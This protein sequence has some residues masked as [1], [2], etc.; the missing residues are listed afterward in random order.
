MVSV[1]ATSGL[2]LYGHSLGA[3]A[4]TQTG[5]P[6]QSD[7]YY[8]NG[9]TGNLVVQ[10]LDERLATLGVDLAMVRT[11]N[12]QGS[13]DGDNNDG[14]R[15]GVY[16]K[17]YGL[18]GTVN[19]SGSTITKVY[20]DGTEAVFTYDTSRSLYVSNIGEN[21]HDTLSWSSGT[22]KWTFKDGND[23]GSEVYNSSGQLIQILD[24]DGNTSTLTYTG[25]LIT[26]IVDASGQTTYLDYT[27]NNLTKVR[28][29]SNSVTQTLTQYTYDG[30]NRL[31]QVKVDLSPADN[32]I[33]DGLTYNTT[34][35][36]D[37]TSTRVASITHG[38]TSTVSFTYELVSSKYRVK[39]I[40]DGEGKVTTFTVV[41]ST[42]TDVTD[43]LGLITSYTFDAQ[44]RLTR[45]QSPT[46]GGVRLQ[47]DY[48]Y[49]SQ[50]N[51]TQVTDPRSN[52]TVLQYD[53]RGNQ[54]L[55]RDALGNTISRVFSSTNQL[56][57]ETVYVVPD[58]DGA[59]SGQP[60]TPLT[61][62]YAYDSEN[63]L[64]FVISAEGRVTEH[65]YATNGTRTSTFV[66]ANAAYSVSGLSATTTLSEA[67]LNTWVGT[68]DLTKLQRTDYAYD[69]RGQLC[70]ITA[71]ASTNASG[72]G[73]ADGTQTV[74]R[75]VYD[76]RGQLIKTIDGRG[77]ST[78]GDPNDYVTSYTYDGVGRLLT[79][80]QWVSGTQSRTT[81]NSYDDANNKLVTT[82]A[83]GLIT[84]SLYDRRGLTVSVASADASQALGTTQYKYD[85]NGRLRITVDPLGNKTHRL[86][87]DAGRVVAVIDATGSLV[88]TVYDKNSNAIKT[89]AYANRPNST[90]LASLVDGSGNPV[91]VTLASVRPSTNTSDRIS[92]T[93]YDSANRAVMTLVAHDTDA[94]KAYV[95]QT[96]Y[97]GA[98]RVTCVLSYSTAITITGLSADPTPANIT[99]LITT[100]SSDRRTRFFYDAES[101]QI[102]SL[103]AEGYLTETVYDAAGRVTRTVAYN[104]VTGS[105]LWASG[106]FAQ[107]KT[108][109]GTNSNDQNTYRFY[110]GKGQII[111]SLD[112]EGYF[113]EYQY[114]L[115][116]NQTQ[117]IRY[118][119]KGTTYTGTQT[120]AQLRPTAHANDQT[121]IN[122][123][124]GANQ[125]TQTTVNPAGTITKFSYDGVGNLTQSE[126]AWNTAEVRTTRARYDAKGRVLQELTGEGSKAVDDFIAANPSATQPQIDAVWAQ[127]SL[128]HAY[129]LA[130]RRISTTDQNGNKTLF[131]YNET[132]RLAY[133]VN[134]LGEVTETRYNALGD[135]T[136]TLRYIGRISTASLVGGVIDST[137]TNR[138]TAVA[139]AAVDIRR[140][141]SYSL[142]G[143]VKQAIDAEGFTTDNTFNAF[144]N[145]TAQTRQ[146][147]SG[148]SVTNN[149]SFDRRGLLT[150]TIEDQGALNRTTVLTYDAFGR[151]TQ[152]VA[153]SGT[154]QAQTTSFTFDRL[155][156]QLSIV[157]PAG[158]CSTTY[159]A[160][161]R[162]LTQTDA[163]SKVTTTTYDDTNRRFT[164]TTP[165]S[166]AIVTTRTRHGET[167]SIT[168]ARNVVTSY[169]YD[170][171]GNLKTEVVD[172][173]SGKLNLTTQHSYDRASLR[174][175]T[176][177]ANGIHC[178]YAYDA[179]SR[180]L[181]KTLEPTGLNIQTTYTFDGV[182]RTL[183]VVEG[184]NTPVQA[185]T[186][187]YAYD[188][189][190]NRLTVTIDPA[191]LNL[192]TTYTYNADGNV[193]TM[194][195]GANVS[196]E[197][198][199]TQYTFDKLGRRTQEAKDPSGLNI[200]TAYGFDLRDN[201]VYK[202]EAQGKPEER[203]TRNVYDTADRLIY[204][205][206]ALGGVTKNDFDANRRITQTTQYG[207]TISLTGLGNTL[208]ASDI[209]SRLTVDAAK[210]HVSRFAFDNDGRLVFTRDVLNQIVERVYDGNGNVIKTI[211]YANTIASGTA[212]TVTAI[213][214]A[215]SASAT[216][217]RVT[218]T[219]FDNA[220]RAAYT[221]DALGY[222]TETKY[223]AKGHIAETI[224]HYDAINTGSLSATPTMADIVSAL[225][226]RVSPNTAKDQH[227]LYVY[228]NAGRVK[229]IT[230]AAGKVEHYGYDALGNK[231]SFTGKKGAM[232][233][234]IQHTW[235]YTYDKAGRLIC[236]TTPVVAVTRLVHNGDGS[237][238]TT[239]TS[240]PLITVIT[241]DALG[242]VKTR[243]EAS[244][245]PEAR[246]TTYVYDRLGR[247]IQTQ[248]PQ[249]NAYNSAADQTANYVG[250][251]ETAVTPTS[252]TYY[253]AFGNAVANKDVRGYFSYKVYDK[254]GRVTH[255]VDAERFVSAYTLDAFG[256]QKTLTRYATA[257]AEA[258]FTA[259]E[260]AATLNSVQTVTAAN[261]TAWLTVSASQDRTIT[262]TYDLLNRVTETKQTAV[263]NYDSTTSQ[264]FTATPITRNEYNTFGQVVRQRT[265]KNLGT[266][267]TINTGDDQ[268]SDKYFY[269]DRLGRKT[270]E[271]DALGFLSVFQYDAN[272]NLTQQTE[273]AAALSPGWTVTS[274][275]SPT[276]T[277]PVDGN[278]V[279][280]IGF[281]RTTRFTY[282]GLNRK[283]TEVKV[284]VQYN[285]ATY[286][287]T[288]SVSNALGDLTTSYGYDA[289][290]NLVSTTDSSGAV[291]R[292]YYDALGRVTAVADP[293]RLVD[294]AG[295][296][297]LPPIS[298]NGTVVSW[299]ASPIAGNIATFKYRAKGASTW[300]DANT[301]NGL[302][303]IVD[304]RYQVS[305][306]GKPNDIYEYELSYKRAGQST[307]YAV[308]TGTFTLTG[309][310]ASG[311]IN[312]VSVVQPVYDS[313]GNMTSV[314]KLVLQGNTTG[315]TAINIAGVGTRSVTSI[316]GGQYTVD[317]SN[318]TRGVYTF[319]PVGTSSTQSGSFELFRS[320]VTGNVVL[321]ENA[322]YDSI[323][324]PDD[325]RLTISNLPKAAV[326][327]T[328]EYRPAGSSMPY[329]TAATPY[330]TAAPF[331]SQT[332]TSIG[333][334]GSPSDRWFMMG[335]VTGEGRQDMVKYEPASGYVGVWKSNGDGTF[336]PGASTYIGA[337]GTPGDRWFTLADITGDGKADLVKFEPSSGYVG[338]W[339][340][341]G[342]GTFTPGSSTYIGAGGS[343][344]DRW[345]VMADTTGDGKADIVKYEPSTG[346]ATVWTSNGNGTFTLG[347]S[348]LVGT[349]GSP[350]DRWFNVADVNGDGRADFVMYNPQD[351][352]A[353]IF[354]S[355]ANGTFAPNGSV[356][357]STGGSP[358]DRW[359][360]AADMNGDGRADLVK[361]EPT[362]G[363]VTVWLARTDGTFTSSLSTY[364]GAGGSPS[365]RWFTVADVND[366]GR[367]D[368]MRYEPASGYV[369]VWL[370]NGD[371]SFT[372]GPST[373]IGSGGSPGDRW[374]TTGDVNNSGRA[375]AIK[376]ESGSGSASNWLSDDY[377]AFATAY[378][379]MGNGQYEYRITA[380]D[381]QG[382][383]IDLTAMG[384]TAQGQVSGT[385]QVKRGGQSAPTMT[386]ATA[387]AV[388]P[389]AVMQHDIFGNV[390]HQTRYANG[391]LSANS[392]GYTL[393]IA[394]A[395][396][397]QHR[398]SF[399]DKHGHATKMV[400]AE[401]A[402]FE[403]SFDVAGN[404]V[405]T[406]NTLTDADGASRQV[407]KLYGYDRLGRQTSIT[408]VM[409][410]SNS[411]IY[412]TLP[413]A[414]GGD[415]TIG[416]G[417]KYMADMNG[418][419][420]S[421]LI[422]IGDAGSANAGKV[423]VATSNGNGFNY[424]TWNSSIRMVDD[425]SETFFGDVNGDGKAD[426]V[427][428]TGANGVQPGRVHVG[429]SDGT[430]FAYWT[431]MTSGRMVDDG[432]QS[433]LADV[434]SDGKADLVNITGATGGQPGRVHVGLSNGTS[435][436]YWTWMTAG[437]MVD[438]YSE[439]QFADVN[440]DGKQDFIDVSPP[441]GNN[442]G[443]VHV[444][445]SNGSSFA[446]WTSVSA[447]NTVSLGNW[448]MADVNGDGKADLVSVIGSGVD[449]GK[450]R[451]GLSNG[452]SFATWT[453]TST[454]KVDLGSDIK[455]AD[456]DGDGKKDLI[457]TAP[458]TGENPG[459]VYVGLSNG[460]GFNFW[461]SAAPGRVDDGGKS[462]IADVT[463]DGKVDRVYTNAANQVFIYANRLSN[464]A[465]VLDSEQSRYNAFGEIDAKGANGTWQ[466]YFHYDQA[467]RLWKTNQ[468]DGAYK[469]YFYNLAG[470]ATATITSAIE[471]LSAAASPSAVA[472]MTAANL[473]RHETKYDALGRVLAQITPTTTGTT[474]QTTQTVD[475]WGNVLSATDPR[476]ATYVTN[477]RYDAWNH[478]IEEVK[479]TT[480]IWLE[481]G[482]NRR[483]DGNSNNDRPT[484]RTYFDSLGRELAVLDANG[485]LS[486][487]KY[488]EASQVI[489]DYRADAGQFFHAY[490]ALG[491]ERIR[492][493]ALGNVRSLSYDR[494]DRLTSDSTL[495]TNRAYTYD[496]L[497]QRITENDGMGNLT[498][499]FY[500]D[501]GNVSKTRLPMASTPT[502]N[503]RFTQTAQYNRRGKKI[504][505]T[506]GL[507]DF[508]TW[509]Y[510]YFGKLQS[511]RDLSGATTS[512]VYDPE[513]GDLLSQA[514]TGGNNPGQSISY[515][516]YANGS[517][518]FITDN[519]LTQETYYEY[520]AA[521]HRTRERI[522]NTATSTTYQDVATTFDELGRVK[523]VSD[524]STNFS[525]SIDYD[526]EGNRRHTLTQ[527][528]DSTNTLQTQDYWYKY[529]AMNRITTAQGKLVSGAIVITADQ[530]SGG[531]LV[532]GQ[533]TRLYYD[534]NGNRALVHFYDH[535][536]L[537]E[538]SYSF[539]S[540]GQLTNTYRAGLLTSA[541]LYNQA[542][543]VIQYTSYSS[544]GVIQAKQ[545]STY[546][547]NGW[548]LTQES[549]DASNVTIQNLRYDYADSY[550]AVGNVRH[551]SLDVMQGM[552]YSNTY[553]KTYTK[554]SSYKELTNE[555]TSNVLLP[556]TTTQTYDVNGNLVS[557]TDSG[558][559][560][561]N[562]SFISNAQGQIIRKTQNSKT[563]DYYYQDG[564]PIG[565][566][567]DVNPNAAVDYTYT[568]VSQGYPASTPNQYTV[569]QGDT[570]K[571]I[572]LAV[573]GDAKLWYLIADANGI[574][575]D[576]GLTPGKVLTIPNVI[577]NIHN[578]SETNRVYSA[579][580]IVEDTTP[581]LPA[582]PPPPQMRGGC[583]AVGQIIVTIVAIVV[584]CLTGQWYLANYGAYGGVVAAAAVGAAAGSV[585]SQLTAMG[586]GMQDKFSWK[587]VASS[588]LVG[589]LTANLGP[590]VAGFNW[591]TAGYG[592]LNNAIS[593]GV[594]I[595]V[596]LQEKF[597]WHQVAAGAIAAPITAAID[598]ALDIGDNKRYLGTVNV[599][600]IPTRQFDMKYLFRS[601]AGEGLKSVVRQY[602]SVVTQGEG[603]IR[604]DRIFT[605]AF[606]NGIGNAIASDIKYSQEQKKKEEQDRKVEAQKQSEQ[607]K[608]QQRVA[609]AQE[610][611]IVNGQAIT[612]DGRTIASDTYANN[613]YADTRLD[614]GGNGDGA[615]GRSGN[616]DEWSN[617]HPSRVAARRAQMTHFNSYSAVPDTEGW[618][619]LTSLGLDLTPG[620]GT[621]K[622]GYQL[623]SGVDPITG[624]P[625]NRWLE[626]VG[627]ILSTVPGG[628]LLSKA[629]EKI[630]E[631][632]A[633]GGKVADSV[634]PK[635]L[636]GRQGRDEMSGSK[637]ERLSKDMK[638]NGYNS[639]HPIDVADVDGKL[640]IVDGH[641]RRQAAV[642]AGVQKVPVNIHSV[643]REQADRLLREIAELQI[644]R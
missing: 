573:Y 492:I 627:L 498:R 366:D 75:V 243:T 372:P 626:G 501:W 628:K 415:P 121:V 113:S 453:S 266:D 294:G 247:Q 209:T 195:E 284:A 384:G 76:Q 32:S 251:N 410:Q 535:T 196:A 170:R 320:T 279:S 31:T 391:A 615:Q 259:N 428:I 493:D 427:N 293:G 348:T 139:N 109:A 444:G 70:T 274:Y 234:D 130:G 47:T 552:S 77:E 585:A 165:E 583:G 483:T 215:L 602:T 584:A 137:L 249:V 273:Y 451:V 119:N 369:G 386:L 129:D 280:S 134:A 599:D 239:T 34:Y 86:Y 449:A 515:T 460:A 349:G 352:N 276:A 174:V 436:A 544:P 324:A 319:T 317:I 60:T 108:S 643:N 322:P 405:K 520:D 126:K 563:E 93:V 507:G 11:Y 419:G 91:N 176:T 46:V 55:V 48:A 275:G 344:G 12:S 343:P 486:G 379:Q 36:Y 491:R 296:Y 417:K 512:F 307:A 65:R 305:F 519:A 205:V 131:Y 566:S 182:G 213:R 445:L 169:T 464:P 158:T 315:I 499:F 595:A 367:A 371:G 572:A 30:S 487:R 476:N 485:Y 362:V 16:R 365:D 407:A 72:V 452:T 361:Y 95:T 166:V 536:A 482:T 440:G 359:F 28:V 114:D 278:S 553:Y 225:A 90:Q 446:G 265:L 8:V 153:A 221:V 398:Y 593:Q 607:Q 257:L 84:T 339:T 116:G 631:L 569:N 242:N 177:D 517:L 429:L 127:Y 323:N 633:Q 442:P 241:Y 341:N 546:N 388:T 201:L 283:L 312:V 576:A 252:T 355:Q 528:R 582:P 238:T 620:V 87:D 353:Y 562:R 450:V 260:A 155:G 335:D 151:V 82:L 236:E 230:D 342:D 268:W 471:N 629:G 497:G 590:K 222:V 619:E 297:K 162:T 58:P 184:S 469:V 49:D 21:A 186:T 606:G 112:Q 484:T 13:V 175:D 183:T 224:S 254:L 111:A 148:V 494:N 185:R 543:R 621:G 281:D 128:T 73:T 244:G 612:A 432:S 530:G 123:Y 167:V 83:N 598:N 455:F 424:W 233:G 441:S 124:D 97:D 478:R 438:D 168:D 23:F 537:V 45:T 187:Q 374:F 117:S 191:G 14:W 308:G 96:Y 447:T 157:D 152:R 457:A 580:Y 135:V 144:G 479:P 575:N 418:D 103:N 394:D 364:I 597:D 33:V 208:I 490:D 20:A 416:A 539:D 178:T 329:L 618:R 351:G 425:G 143:L 496:Q 360:L 470:Q 69:F 632:V 504:S 403:S 610:V 588:A 420:K 557:L 248:H 426:L 561:N 68:Q 522:K 454:A 190:G 54:T 414:S 285:T 141:S 406:W 309:Q 387:T 601:V 40:T 63:H 413:T 589:A 422:F 560:S 571:G 400:D 110:N 363:R 232:V 495:V 332:S 216:L 385:F 397:D 337:G 289:V 549:K 570:L 80:T 298:V 261:I 122:V 10:A 39:T 550:D 382:N 565:A 267:N 101:R 306:A 269:F 529:D 523:T 107:L 277:T 331:K 541:R 357:I 644:K 443:A 392:S 214:A 138:V 292:S 104:T 202:I 564:H 373:Y 480:D 66:Y 220:N 132:N 50:G 106:T 404:V 462:F 231:T 229:Q 347:S 125:L 228:D 548:L 299:E 596:G 393:D 3:S 272:D 52:A 210:D 25:S 380:R 346:Y 638:V 263:Y 506:N 411:P 437:R 505:E 399:Y 207:N 227:T 314:D 526:A 282:D 328:L 636:L 149:Y 150:Q 42:Q 192:Q 35:T 475:R 172:E 59:G 586:L 524:A 316:G 62:R 160:F 513:S 24:A 538:E 574:A 179:A 57:N 288:M 78:S 92:S 334:G 433:Y 311:S 556:S 159:D 592:A 204:T 603:R 472:A 1:L 102:G 540:A 481:N 89:I 473:R 336:T 287:S 6:G 521:L 19:T 463:G 203:I 189:N 600:G 581:M 377:T 395:A 465:F 74:T 56:Q 567:G 467:A 402:V 468:G 401:R 611:R 120:I 325:R 27:G 26:Q 43:P 527:Y 508:Q 439:Y 88:E 258:N 378:G 559:P 356:Y 642:R 219:V 79:T 193:L 250:R 147:T 516:Y 61:T 71:F 640:V 212:N 154:S 38:D 226:A 67:Q 181:T 53:T 578:D 555:A 568:P 639:N 389:I 609:N 613:Q 509:T 218:R 435:F 2:G 200:V 616:N 594:N 245:A 604:V 194:V 345:F 456:V 29:V 271:V 532:K 525:Q 295:S 171:N 304:S 358:A 301:T 510:D 511:T 421:D 253:D 313:G 136:D 7:T 286:G 534:A 327:V 15:I 489:A 173:G 64:R 199:T 5:R 554:Y 310:S 188:R 300:I 255:E 635:V 105:G 430:S 4:G 518:K 591:Q 431:W 326:N 264:S 542:S 142:R 617:D 340:S 197:S 545:T 383:L 291:S 624:E 641:H 625:V 17:V 503:V 318:L 605:D 133:T 22:S 354:L 579:G 163:L 375:D 466:E 390:V 376:Y 614:A 156:R 350:G 409:Q 37:G 477:F 370:S 531:S 488:D 577:S 51:L 18:T 608:F 623:F 118:Y 240:E 622:S 514:R 302:V 9:S 100:A 547:G 423:Y 180:L 396:N 198:R 408:D 330:K 235:N 237:V 211:A 115:A 587:Q 500:D 206:D 140:Q 321:Q 368:L 161:S 637:V 459:A 146:I 99:A 44:G 290:G 217:D 458:S 333:S 94:T 262:N 558:T 533:G 246:T 145:V 81:T 434:N 630:I 338:V 98:S 270:A 223:D 381:R 303:T 502:T 634:D 448:Y 85:S 474:A 256:N 461:S 164:M 412:G 551:Y 41:S